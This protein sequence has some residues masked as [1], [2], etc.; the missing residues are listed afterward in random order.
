MANK[1]H[2]G[3]R[4]CDDDDDGDADAEDDGDEVFEDD[5]EG[6]DKYLSFLYHDDQSQDEME[7]L[8]SVPLTASSVEDEESDVAARA[9]PKSRLVRVHTEYIEYS[10]IALLNHTNFH[11]VFIM[12]GCW[13]KAQMAVYHPSRSLVR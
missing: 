1:K 7:S 2:L 4:N 5:N 10:T 9:L 11:V 6:S 3:R 8:S 12:F 13:C